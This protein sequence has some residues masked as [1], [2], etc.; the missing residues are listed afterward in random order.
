[1]QQGLIFNGHGLLKQA[2]GKLSEVAEVRYHY[3]V[4]LLKSGEKTEANKRLNELLQSKESFEGKQDIQ[5]LLG[6]SKI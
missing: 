3:A 4:A 2:M 6:N 5:G 1:V